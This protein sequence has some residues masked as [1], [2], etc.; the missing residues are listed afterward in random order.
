MPFPIHLDRQAAAFDPNS[1]KQRLLPDAAV[2]AVASTLRERLL[3]LTGKCHNSKEDADDI[4]TTMYC[5]SSSFPFFTPLIS[6]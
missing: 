4:D 6:K 1:Y 5:W 3:A 2:L